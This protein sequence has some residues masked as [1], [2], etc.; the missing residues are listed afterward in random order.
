[1]TRSTQGSCAE[2]FCASVDVEGDERAGEVELLEDGDL[3]GLLAA[4]DPH[5]LDAEAER[6]EQP[7]AEAAD[8]A[9]DD[10]ARRGW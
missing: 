7:V 9:A 6:D 8:L 5:V 10:E 1:M 2:R 3:G 4:A